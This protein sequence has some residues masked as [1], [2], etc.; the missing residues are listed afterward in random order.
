M[1]STSSK[2]AIS[3]Q[4]WADTVKFGHAHEIGSILTFHTSPFSGTTEGLTGAGNSALT[5]RAYIDLGSLNAKGAM[6][7][8]AALTPVVPEPASI[9]ML[10]GALLLLGSALRRQI[11]RN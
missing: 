5:I 6:S 2:R 1:S 8:D 10:G 3:F 11:K 7:F 4:A 9:S